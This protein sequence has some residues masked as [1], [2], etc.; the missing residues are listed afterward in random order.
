MPF[1][2][3]RTQIVAWLRSRTTSSKPCS[4]PPG[5]YSVFARYGTRRGRSIAVSVVAE[6]TSETQ[7][8]LR[9]ATHLVSQAYCSALPVAYS[10]HSEDLWSGFGQLVLEA[11][12]EA[13]ICAGI[14]NLTKT[15]SR[16]VFLTLLGGGAFGNPEDWIFPAIHRS[17]TEF[18]DIDLDVAVV[19]Y[20]SSNPR[21]RELVESWS[22]G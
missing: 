4:F 11:S 22:N 1:I 19:S 3:S 21:V 2:H 10:V 5:E 16:K 6:Q 8:T 9:D 12:Y 7:V 17:L 18:S 20:G 13:A 14:L 15:G